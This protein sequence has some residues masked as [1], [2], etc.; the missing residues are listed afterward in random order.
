[1]TTKILRILFLLSLMM[2]QTAYSQPCDKE[3][4]PVE[5]SEIQYKNRGNRCEGFYSSKVSAGS[6]EVVGLV[7]GEVHFNLAKDEM[8]EITSPFVKSKSV[9]V[10][11]VGIPIRTYYRMD[12]EIPLGKTLKW[13]IGDIIY[14]QKLSEDKIG[15][16]GWIGQEEN[17]DF[18]VPIAVATDNRKPTD[19]KLMLYLRT[20]IDVENVK[21]RVSEVVKGICASPG[22]WKDTP[23][24]TYRSGQPIE[25]VLP[26]SKENICV[27]VA[28][29]EKNSSSWLTRSVPICLKE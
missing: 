1:M 2:I 17:I 24:S 26:E 9:Y 29:R 27:E 4:T 5:N 7:K 14:P 18:Y 3:L 8:I 13:N 12:A 11:A 10:R 28:A 23:Q 20:S 15:V 21:W 6:I 16:F 22:D 25:I 19:A